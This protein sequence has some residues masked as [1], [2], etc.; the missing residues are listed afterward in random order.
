MDYTVGSLEGGKVG[1][2]E[3]SSRRLLGN[4]RTHYAIC[5]DER[6]ICQIKGTNIPPLLPSSA[7]TSVNAA[8]MRIEVYGFGCSVSASR[9]RFGWK[10]DGAKLSTWSPIY[11]D[12]CS[13]PFYAIRKCFAACGWWKEPSAGRMGQILMRT[14]LLSPRKCGPLD[15]PENVT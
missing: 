11:M 13:N 6:N 3:K 7:I 2:M 10:C 4:H 1:R 12:R 15:S 8:S 5:I 14:M 9:E